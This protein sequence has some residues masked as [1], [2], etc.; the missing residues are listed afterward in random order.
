M[1]INSEGS[2][3]V[4]KS[5]VYGSIGLA[6]FIICFGVSYFVPSFFPAGSLYML[7]GVLILLVNMVKSLKSIGYDVL[8]VLLGAAFIVVGLNRL[9]DLDLGFFPA[10]IIVL[11]GILLIKSIKR[12][13]NGQ[14]F[15]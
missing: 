8:E 10:F 7:A 5:T 6:V 13:R 11:A 15:V 9:L 14:V 4:S 12:L 1:S 2:E 3:P